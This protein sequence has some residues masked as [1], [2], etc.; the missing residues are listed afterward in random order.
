[1]WDLY[2]LLKDFDTDAV[3]VNYDVCHGT[4]EGGLG[5]WVHSSRLLL[6]YTRGAA[7]KDFKWQ[8]DVKGRWVPGWCPLGQGMVNFKVFL[9]MLKAA[10]F[11]GPLQHHL[12]FP[13]LG[14]ASAGKKQSSIPKEKLLAI[15]RRDFGVLKN[16]LREAGM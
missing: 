16:L 2:L 15:V 7:I 13:E 9:P 4:V 6:P 11:T 10:R 1:M 3:S 8:Q 5:G 12:E 14:D